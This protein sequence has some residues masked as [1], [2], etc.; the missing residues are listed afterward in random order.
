VTEFVPDSKTPGNVVVAGRAGGVD[1]L[2]QA[3]QPPPKDLAIL[4]LG[5]LCGSTAPPLMAAVAVPALAI[6]FWR[7]AF[8]LLFVW[9]A[10][11]IRE[12]RGFATVT[13]RVAV[14][15]G[16]AATML[17]VHFV[18]MATS[19]QYTSVASAAALVCSQSIWAALFARL[20][21]E[22]LRPVAWI[23]TSLAFTGVLVVTGIDLSVSGRALIGDV[24]AIVAGMAG[25]AYMVTGGVIRR[26]VGLQV[27]TALCYSICAL[28][29]LVATLIAG[30]QLWGYSGV[31]W[32]QLVLLTVL[33]QLFGHSIFNLVMRSVSPSFVS[34]GQLFTMPLS[35]VLAALL[36]NQTPPAA[37]VPAMGLMLVGTALVVVSNRRQAAGSAGI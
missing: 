30:Q 2:S 4:F 3:S 10:A 25:G 1:L 28:V 18:G 20:L 31:A 17:A 12:R 21:G 32:G 34:L 11:V 37:A 13:W 19:L 27:Y 22:R 7:N 16:F 15:I 5:V 14:A 8:A 26:R 9:P 36:L 23:G 24:L 33:A 29:T 6:A 35:A